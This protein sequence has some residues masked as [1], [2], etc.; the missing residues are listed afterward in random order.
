[1]NK[2]LKALAQAKKATIDIAGAMIGFGVGAIALLIVVLI[3]YSV[4]VALPTTDMSAAGQT[5]ISAVVTTAGS[6][7]SLL[8]ITLIVAASVVII[9]T[10]MVLRR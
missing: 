7:W 6:G 10:L 3:F 1:M 2:L 5:K 4:E 8:T 9:G